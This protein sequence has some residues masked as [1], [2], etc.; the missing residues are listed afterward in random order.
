MLGYYVIDSLNVDNEWEEIRY[1]E[2]SLCESLVD[3]NKVVK[4]NPIIVAQDNIIEFTIRE[5]KFNKKGKNIEIVA[6]MIHPDNFNIKNYEFKLILD[7]YDSKE[8]NLTNV[9]KILRL[10]VVSRSWKFWLIL[11][12]MTDC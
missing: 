3:F 12:M 8:F 6:D 5:I 9:S 11:I 1:D 2:K 7:T 10:S 4:L